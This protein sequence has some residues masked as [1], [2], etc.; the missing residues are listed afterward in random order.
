MPFSQKFTLVVTGT[1]CFISVASGQKDLK[2]YYNT[3]NKLYNKEN[4]TKAIQY[5]DSVLTINPYFSSAYFKLA[6]CHYNLKFYDAALHD[7]ER[8]YAYRELDNKYFYIKSQCYDNLKERDLTMYYLNMAINYDRSNSYYYSYRGGINL[9]RGNYTDA[10]SDYSIA[11]SIQPDAYPLYYTRGMA[12]YNLKHKTAACADWFYAKDKDKSCNRYYFYECTDEDA[13]KFHFDIPAPYH[14]IPQPQ[15]IMKGDTG[16][17][18]FCAH[19]LNY[20]ESALLAQHQGMVII[21][22]TVSADGKITNI[23]PI[24]SAWP[25][26]KD[27]SIRVIRK[28]EPYWKPAIN[29]GNPVDYTYVLPISF[30][31][32][33][34][35][36]PMTDA[37]DT[38]QH[39]Y[40]KN[41][42]DR[43]VRLSDKVIRSNPFNKEIFDL[44]KKFFTKN[45]R[46]DTC[47]KEDWFTK[48]TSSGATFLPS[49]MPSK[50][51]VRI[52]FNNL[53]EITTPDDASFYRITRWG[54]NAFYYD[55]SYADYTIK[56]QLVSTGKYVSGDRNG[57]FKFYYPDGTLKE[58]I[59]F[60]MKHPDGIWKIYYPDSKLNLVINANY[61][62]YKVA[63]CYDSLGKNMLKNGSGKWEYTFPNYKNDYYNKLSG[64]LQNG[65]RVGHWQYWTGDRLFIDESYNSGKLIVSNYFQGVRENTVRKILMGPWIFIPASVLR[66]E[67][68]LKSDK[69][70]EMIFPTMDYV[71]IK[72][73]SLLRAVIK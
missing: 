4:Y 53:W 70:T 72:G 17:V 58:D 32:L 31:I 49:V 46:T 19:N 20:P 10:I 2:E 61:D 7:I 3:G 26:L 27:E 48:L 18:K 47:F 14:A 44:R 63:E 57:E 1:I 67:N 73:N 59:S 55:G 28:S 68:M 51:Y 43:F 56:G 23:T 69:F 41:D 30:T 65:K 22:F 15:F 24:F 6:Y 66:T 13:A 5:F 29:N 25:E 21:Q 45:N 39:L 36:Y 52:Y 34:S 71:E 33:E 42:F 12:K 8:D 60:D 62:S 16:I 11:L 40:K 9:V 38:L 64:Q 50:K 35:G 37:L 54:S